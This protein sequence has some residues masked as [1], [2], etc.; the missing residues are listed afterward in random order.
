MGLD[1]DLY[2]VKRVVK[3]SDVFEI[4]NDE[5]I[6]VIYWRKFRTLQ[7]FM[8]E[9]WMKYSSPHTIEPNEEDLVITQEILE[10]LVQFLNEAE[11]EEL[12]EYQSLEE[13]SADVERSVACFKTLLI[14]F[15]FEQETLI[16]GCS[17]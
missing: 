14:E 17:Y 10:Q 5:L 11:F 13:W 12:K 6:D 4:K 1:M 9:L 2:R 3:Q 15:N 7:S 16:Y 8:N